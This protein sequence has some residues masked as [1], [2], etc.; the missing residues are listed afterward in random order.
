M[1]NSPFIKQLKACAVSAKNYAL[2]KVLE[3]IESTGAD[4]EALDSGKADK[5]TAVSCTIQTTGW[6][7]DSTK[8]YPQFYDIAVNGLTSQDRAEVT[9]TLSS[10]EIA[11]NC[12]MCRN[13][14]TMAGKIR[15]RAVSVPASDITAEYWIEQGKG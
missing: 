12:G 15:L 6:K 10:L 13:C 14:E 4:L 11:A 2:E 1:G 3:V 7:S 8:D 9:L 5:P